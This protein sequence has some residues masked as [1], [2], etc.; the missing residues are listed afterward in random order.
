MRSS[1]YSGRQSRKIQTESRV[2]SRERANSKSISS[3]PLRKFE[4][5]TIS[6]FFFAKEFAASLHY[7]KWAHLDPFIVIGF[8]LKVCTSGFLHSYRHAVGLLA[9]VRVPYSNLR[10][11]K[12]RRDDNSCHVIIGNTFS[13]KRV[14][15]IRVYGVDFICFLDICLEHSG[16]SFE[17]KLYPDGCVYWVQ[18]WSV[19][20]YVFILDSSSERLWMGSFSWLAETRGTYWTQVRHVMVDMPAVVTVNTHK[21]K[22]VWKEGK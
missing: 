7:Q 5:S 3:P 20:G 13:M 17:K 16:I 15:Q 18:R 22:V 19:E 10:N 9:W 8:F 1:R 2:K 11:C 12:K 6:S 14:N 4:I 21:Y